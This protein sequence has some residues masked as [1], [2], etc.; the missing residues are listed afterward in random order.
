M[1]VVYHRSAAS[2][3]SSLLQNRSHAGTI[4]SFSG[5]DY[6]SDFIRV[7]QNIT[8]QSPIKPR[9]QAHGCCRP[10]LNNDQTSNET[11]HTRVKGLALPFLNIY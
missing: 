6:I 2:P 5:L 10:L 11:I 3:S 4:E 7:D 8:A 1:Q 9:L